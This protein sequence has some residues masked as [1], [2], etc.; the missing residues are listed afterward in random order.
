MAVAV[1]RHLPAFLLLFVLAAN[2]LKGRETTRRLAYY[3]KKQNV[4]LVP[5]MLSAGLP[6]SILRQGQEIGNEIPPL[7]D[8]SQNLEQEY[9]IYLCLSNF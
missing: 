9:H 2:P 3:G 4:T 1:P 6:V 7:P 8:P 5:Q